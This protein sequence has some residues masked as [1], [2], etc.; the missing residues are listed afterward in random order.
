MH[1]PLTKTPNVPT[2]ACSSVYFALEDSIANAWSR[3]SAFSRAAGGQPPLRQRGQPAVPPSQSYTHSSKVCSM[4]T[5][6]CE[7]HRWECNRWWRHSAGAAR[8]GFCARAQ[9]DRKDV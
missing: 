9:P 5:D 4:R 3:S 8:T 7:A 1:C 6:A 2:S